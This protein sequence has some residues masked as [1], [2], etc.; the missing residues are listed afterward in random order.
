M[1]WWPGVWNDRGQLREMPLLITTKP[2]TWLS[3]KTCQIGCP[4]LIYTLNWYPGPQHHH[5]LCARHWTL[6]PVSRVQINFSLVPNLKL[7]LPLKVAQALAI[8][9]SL[10]SRYAQ[11]TRESSCLD[12][13]NVPQTSASHTDNIWLTLLCSLSSLVS[14][15]HTQAHAHT[16]TC[17]RARTLLIGWIRFTVNICCF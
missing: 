5:T 9:F 15:V 16:H 7:F 2:H 8:K 10:L 11:P 1:Q 12:A 6:G 14:H 13:H 17:A 4:S 3:L